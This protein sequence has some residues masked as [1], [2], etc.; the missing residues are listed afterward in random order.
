MEVVKLK[1]GH[2]TRQKHVLVR[3]LKQKPGRLSDRIL[4]TALFEGRFKDQHHLSIG[5]ELL[6]RKAPRDEAGWSLSRT[7][8]VERCN[9]SR[10]QRHVEVFVVEI[11]CQRLHHS[12]LHAKVGRNDLACDLE[13]RDIN[14]LFPQ[15]ADGHDD[16]FC[17]RGRQ[18]WQTLLS[19]LHCL[20]PITSWDR[21]SLHASKLSCW[22]QR[23]RSR[24]ASSGLTP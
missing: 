6:E 21:W 13:P 10:K 12:T 16:H 14:I 17:S 18:G 15:D 5:G 8:R 19:L 9:R 20:A 1:D 23:G 24:W 7:D 4:L 2:G 11:P 22:Q 3:L